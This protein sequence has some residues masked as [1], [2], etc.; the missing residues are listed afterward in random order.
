M[1]LL[2]I[3]IVLLMLFL[4]KCFPAVVAS[5]YYQETLQNADLVKK[6]E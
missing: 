1:V 6:A 3:Y 4:S 5:F 2:I